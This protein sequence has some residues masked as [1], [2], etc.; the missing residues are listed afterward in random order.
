MPRAGA[1][2]NTRAMTSKQASVLAGFAGVLGAAAA[3]A[4]FALTRRRRAWYER[5]G[6]VL[7]RNGHRARRPVLRR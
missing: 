3:L 2:W 7:P 5:L 6:E 4:A 1:D